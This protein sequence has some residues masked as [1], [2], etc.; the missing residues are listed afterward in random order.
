MEA[1]I[2]ITERTDSLPNARLFDAWVDGWANVVSKPQMFA[3]TSSQAIAWKV[4]TTSEL[5]SH[6]RT[7]GTDISVVEVHENF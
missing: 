5:F 2:R 1:K 3:M 7:T 6:S 4:A